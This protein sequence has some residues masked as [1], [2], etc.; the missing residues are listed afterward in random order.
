MG[1]GVGS[2]EIIALL[3]K[4]RPNYETNSIGVALTERMLDFGAEMEASVRRLNVG[5]DFFL[6]EMQL[7]GFKTLPA[8]AS[9]L[10]VNF[11]MHA[12]AIHFALADKVLYRKDFGH[13]CLKGYSRFSSTTRELFSPLVDCIK[14]VVGREESI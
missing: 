12:E 3:H 9:F 10:H 11:G 4:V 13:S 2:P 14:S 8:F 1:Y 7:L 6:S 5:R